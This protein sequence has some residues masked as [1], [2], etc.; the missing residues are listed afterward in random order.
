VQ[1]ERID[2]GAVTADVTDSELDRALGRCRSSR[3]LSR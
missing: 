2:S 3:A 1:V